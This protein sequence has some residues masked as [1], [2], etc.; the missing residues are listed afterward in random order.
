MISLKPSKTRVNLEPAEKLAAFKVGAHLRAAQAG[1]SME[2]LAG[3]FGYTKQAVGETQVAQTVSKAGPA[4]AA[5]AANV[6]DTVG[7]GRE[8]VKGIFGDTLG[9]V[10][11]Y[12]SGVVLTSLLTGIP[13]GIVAHSVGRSANKRRMKEQKLLSEIDTYD[14]ATRNL[15]SNLSMRN[16]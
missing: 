7:K 6:L 1:M 8:A 4:A 12:A 15:A 5:T 11:T 9:L 2:E 13:I 3:V 14:D 10:K 16:T